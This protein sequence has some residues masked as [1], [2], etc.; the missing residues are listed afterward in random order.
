MLTLKTSDQL[1]GFELTHIENPIMAIRTI[2][3]N[4]NQYANSEPI[5]NARDYNL[6]DAF[7]RVYDPYS[8]IERQLENGEVF[9]VNTEALSPVFSNIRLSEKRTTLCDIDPHQTLMFLS[10]ADAMLRDVR[11]PEVWEVVRQAPAPDNADKP[12]VQKIEREKHVIL[13]NLTG[14]K[15]RP[16]PIKHNITLVVENSSQGNFPVRQLKEVIYD[17]FSRVFTSE[18]GDE[19]KVYA[20]SDNMLGVKEDFNKNKNLE[21]SESA[22]LIKPLQETGQETRADG[23]ILHHVKYEV[24][25]NYIEI[26]LLDEGN[27]PEAGAK[28]QIL[29]ESGKI[30]FH[31]NLDENGYAIV[32]GIDINDAVVFFPGIEKEAVYDKAQGDKA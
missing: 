18:Q 17:S 6:P 4:N 1:N 9:L 16:L 26:E 3:S 27:K 30:M 25:N 7:T 28:Y 15:D 24:P 21:Q 2:E 31:G 12:P 20:I 32:E 14:Q 19:F 11:P 22:G 29:N 8:A 5:G 10:A 23:V 13:L